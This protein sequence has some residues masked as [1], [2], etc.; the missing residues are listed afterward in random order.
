MK[1]VSIFPVWVLVFGRNRTSELS[2]PSKAKDVIREALD[3]RA[4]VIPT[5]VVEYRCA[6]TAQKI[7]PDKARIAVFAIRKMEL[8]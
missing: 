3:M 4:V 8:R 6:A 2:K 5:F 1:A 7:N